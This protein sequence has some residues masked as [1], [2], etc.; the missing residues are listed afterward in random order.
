M[1]TEADK[2][3]A[4][5]VI[6][7]KLADERAVCECMKTVVDG[8]APSLAEAMIETGVLDRES[9]GRALLESDPACPRGSEEPAEDGPPEIDGYEILQKL[10]EG[11]MG[12]V[13]LA[14]QTSLDRLVAIKILP[15]AFSRSEKL[16]ARFRR[17]A[18]ATAKLNHPN[19]V[20]AIDV[21]AQEREGEPDLYYF[22]IEYVDG[23]SLDDI[24]ERTGKIEAMRAAQIA[25]DV[26]TALDHAWSEAGIVHR[27]VKPANILITK[28][29]EVKLADLGLARSSYESAGLTTAGLAIGTPHYASPEQALGKAEIDV[30]SDIYALGATLFHMVTGRPPFEG[31]SAAAVMVR[32][33][34]EDA[35]LCTAVNPLVSQWLAAVVAKMM[36]RDP[37]ERYQTPGELRADLERFTSGNRPLAYTRVLD[38]CE[39]A[40]GAFSSAPPEVFTAAMPR[41]EVVRRPRREPRHWPHAIASLL[42]LAAVG[43]GLWYFTKGPAPPAPPA[44]SKQRAAVAAG[45]VALWLGISNPDRVVGSGGSFP[46]SFSSKSGVRCYVKP[47]TPSYIYTVM[48]SGGGS[49][50]PLKLQLLTPDRASPMPLL[51]NALTQSPER[52]GFHSLP[53]SAGVVAF[54][55]VASE[56]AASR[57]D[58]LTS[59]AKISSEL[60][61]RAP[62]LRAGIARGRTFWYGDPEKGWLAGG[63]RASGDTAAMLTLICERMGAIFGEGRVSMCGAA[64]SCRPES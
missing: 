5:A 19:I 53:A 35:P 40:H 27:D 10:G 38:A 34:N 6:R 12:S 46:A 33:V 9:A 29:G 37:A 32:H 44:A 25:I 30:R 59:L 11:G 15:P 36:K 60:S 20:S 21:G 23:E 8:D 26:A 61:S 55:A 16:V 13:W 14:R 2:S 51:T 54:I 52:G 7:L 24:I 48:V 39:S 64:T 31:D 47:R 22:V 50:G 1:A 49:S 4:D 42:F 58:V 45:P 18:L 43:F 17:E 41:P 57:A 63:E 28:T 3:F 56:E 62:G